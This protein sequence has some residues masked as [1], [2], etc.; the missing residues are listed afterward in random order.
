M[1]D[2]D[3]CVLC[4]ECCIA[5]YSPVPSTP[6]AV[7]D[8]AIAN[9]ECRT[10]MGAAYA[11][12]SGTEGQ[13]TQEQVDALNNESQDTVNPAKPTKESR[14]TVPVQPKPSSTKYPKPA[15]SPP[16]KKQRKLTDYM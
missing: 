6:C 2:R 8:H 1:S 4:C 14:R 10:R 7:V 15:P 5:W 12:N 16:S 3:S 9:K 11:L 13:P